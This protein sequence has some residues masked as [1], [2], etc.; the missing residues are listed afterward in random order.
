[1]FAS[2]FAFSETVTHSPVR[3]YKA[4]AGSSTSDSVALPKLERPEIESMN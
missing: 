3:S 2:M 1:M 4:C